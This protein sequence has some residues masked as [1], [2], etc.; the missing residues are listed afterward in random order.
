MLMSTRTDDDR[1]GVRIPPAALR[2]V[3]VDIPALAQLVV[4]TVEIDD[5]GPLL[6]LAP[7][8][9]AHAWVRNGEGLVAWGEALRI[10]TAGAGRFIEAEHAW[11]DV[12][13]H[14]VVRDEVRRRGT[15]LV[16]LGSFAFSDDSPAGGALVV[17]SVLVGQR[18]GRCWL[19]RVTTGRELPGS[20][21]P[22]RPRPAPD[23]VDVVF[24]DGA[25]PGPA[26]E[27]V[28]ATAVSRIETGEVDK[29]VLARDLIARAA[30]PVDPRAVLRRLAER[31]PTTWTFAVD[32]LLGAT[33]EM[34][35]R[36]E[37]GLV[38]SRVLAGT[39]RRSGN[40]ERDLALAAS[41]TRSGKD[42]V[43]HQ[44]AVRSVADSLRPLCS[45][46]NVPEGPYVLHLAN[47]M[48]LATDVT[49]VLADSVSSL[50]IA[51]A[52]HPSAA[53]GGTPTKVAQAVITE[54][55]GMDRDRYAGPVGWLDASGD[56]EW[57]IALRCG[58]VS[59]DR[60]EVRLFAGCG[61][62]A[63]SDPEAELAESAAKFVP[64]RDALTG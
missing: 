56:G 17:P 5:P 34:L 38:A 30:E 35:A 6:D 61:I 22:L 57:A 46:M 19:T 11:R 18:D 25:L 3:P 44:F 23:P 47:V 62:V 32:G 55:E 40:D 28:I 53:V 12:V 60:R 64:M 26:W 54:I 15:G 41:L 13:R 16:A 59:E 39:I 42:L 48:H 8:P 24:V 21:E 4:R 36:T 29:V 7:D 14:A 10:G 51:A 31:Y 43:E 20:M 45:G 33:P 52:L 2:G 27:S 50:A 63:G 9:S 49:G 37:G 58:R 1:G